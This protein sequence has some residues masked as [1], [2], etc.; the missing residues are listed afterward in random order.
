M[1][2]ALL[3][4]S[5]LQKLIQGNQMKVRNDDAADDPDA[6]AVGVFAGEKETRFQQV[7]KNFNRGR[8][9]V[10]STGKK[11]HYTPP[12]RIKRRAVVLAE[13]GVGFEKIQRTIWDITA[14]K[15]FLTRQRQLDDWKKVVQ[16]LEGQVLQKGRQRYN[17][18]GRKEGCT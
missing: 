2:T 11:F 13:Q 14:E 9:A 6:V 15:C 1:M 5:G 18:A 10:K 17:G 7:R 8:G 4:V 16:R 12:M 3:M